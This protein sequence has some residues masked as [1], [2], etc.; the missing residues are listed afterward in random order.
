MYL[1]TKDGAKTKTGFQVENGK[2]VPL[3]LTEIFKLNKMLLHLFLFLNICRIVIE[4]AYPPTGSYVTHKDVCL[5]A[6]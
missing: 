1:T 4:R 6:L 2:A 5:V 3:F